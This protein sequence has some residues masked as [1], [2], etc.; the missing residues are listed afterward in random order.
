MLLVFSA[1]TRRTRTPTGAEKMQHREDK[2]RIV[3][4]RLREID[5][6]NHRIL[7]ECTEGSNSISETF[8]TQDWDDEDYEQLRAYLDKDIKVHL[9]EHE[10]SDWE[11]SK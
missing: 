11:P 2:S 9:Q 1:A 10:V 4:G 8:S 7:V 3:S 6:K 5:K